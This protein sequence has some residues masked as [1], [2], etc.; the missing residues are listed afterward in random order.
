MRA[1]EGLSRFLVHYDE[2]A[3]TPSEAAELTLMIAYGAGWFRKGIICVCR[4]NGE[5]VINAYPIMRE[6]CEMS[7]YER[8]QEEAFAESP[9]IA[10][11]LYGRMGYRT[12]VWN[13]VQAQS[14][15]A[16]DS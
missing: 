13:Q 10:E 11:E 8:H 6:G 9:D 1:V 15:V 14:E 4:R 2:P 16:V 5:I 7:D 3:L 12:W